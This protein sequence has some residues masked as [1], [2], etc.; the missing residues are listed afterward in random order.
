[1]GSLPLAKLLA[2]SPTLGCVSCDVD[3]STGEEEKHSLSHLHL[4]LSS[5]WVIPL[6]SLHA[7]HIIV[8]LGPLLFLIYVNSI[9]SIQ[10]SESTKFSLYADDMLIYKAISASSNYRELQEDINIIFQWS[11]ENLLTF[12]TV[13]CKCM[14]LSKK[15]TTI[16]SY[17]TMMLND[18]PLEIVQQYKYLGLL[19]SSN[20][21]WTPHIRSICNKA[22]RILCLIYRKF[23][24]NTDCFV[25]LRLNLALVRPHL[26]YA[27]QVWN[28][29]LVMD[30]NRLE[31]VQKFALGECARNDNYTY[32]ELLIGVRLICSKFFLLFYST[33]LINFPYYS[34]D[35]ARLFFL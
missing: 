2:D 28:P 15:R 23:L 17:P 34:F 12:N 35:Y 1:M 30:K 29:H 3:D 32:E 7:R 25:T 18:Q 21:S 19:V 11:V 8:V 27:V 13:K 26:E 16:D 10:L 22:R 20:L 33:V 9:S 6:C 24:R 14:L 5:D 4:L 31:K